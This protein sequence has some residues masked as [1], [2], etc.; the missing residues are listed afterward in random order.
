MGLKELLEL[1]PVN[2]DEAT[3]TSGLCEQIIGPRCPCWEAKVL[4]TPQIRKT[5]S[6]FSLGL[7]AYLLVTMSCK[8]TYQ[9]LRGP[10]SL[11]N[12]TEWPQYCRKAFCTNVLQHGQDNRFGPNHVIPSQDSD[13]LCSQCNKEASL[14]KWE[15]QEGKTLVTKAATLAAQMTSSLDDLETWVSSAFTLASTSGRVR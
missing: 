11:D 1:A 7:L 13:H 10:T 3:D 15:A 6:R 8:I 2:T 14:A 12:P 4:E 5:R 9:A